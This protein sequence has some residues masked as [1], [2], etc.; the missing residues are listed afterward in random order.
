MVHE[1]VLPLAAAAGEDRPL[2]L[3]KTRFVQRAPLIGRE[4]R[5]IAIE[6]LI[7]PNPLRGTYQVQRDPCNE[8]ALAEPAANLATELL[9]ELAGAEWVAHSDVFPNP[10]ERPVVT[11]RPE[12]TDEVV[13]LETPAEQQYASEQRQLR[14]GTTTVFL[15]LQRQTELLAARARELQAQ[16]DLNKAVSALNRATGSTLQANNDAVKTD[17]VLPQLEQTKPADDPTLPDFDP[18]ISRG[19]GLP[20]WTNHLAFG[21]DSLDELA[22]R[23]QR[24]LDHGVDVAEIDHGWC[25]SIYAMDPND[26]MVE[27][28]CTTAATT[29][30]DRRTAETLLTAARPEL[31]TPPEPVFHS[32][33]AATV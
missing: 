4:G 12:R 21:A 10:P 32:A 33:A 15:V 31:E 17:A 14:A 1:L 16:T 2:Q 11:F 7:P 22:A 6:K 9:R 30:A 13:G 28:C 19:L 29:D 20:A 25:T 18:S 3:V 23:R 27:F 24:W 5:Q 8:A 26:I